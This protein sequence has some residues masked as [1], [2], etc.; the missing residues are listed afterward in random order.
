MLTANMVKLNISWIIFHDFVNVIL[1]FWPWTNY[2]HVAF[3]YI[4]KLWQFIQMMF[5]KESSYFC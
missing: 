3:Q 5:S 4:Q 1:P 2:R